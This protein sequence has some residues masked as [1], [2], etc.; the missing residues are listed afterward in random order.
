M[1]ASVEI[2]I[3]AILISMACAI[4]GTFLVL[5]KMSMMTDSITHTILFGIVAAYFITHDLNSPFLIVGAALV[6]VLTVWL[7]ESIVKT[8]LV[9]EDSA[10]GLVFPLL[11]SFAIIMVTKFADSVHLDVDTVLLGELAFAPFDRLILF[12]NDVGA[13]GMWIGIILVA[14]NLLF[15]VIFFRVL[16]LSTFDTVLATTLGFSPIIVHYLLMTVVSITT[17]GAFQSVG[18]ILVIAFMIVPP[19][20]AYLLSDDVKMIILISALI[21]AVSSVFGYQLAKLLDASIAGAIAV[22]AG[23]IFAIV[24]VV[25]PKRGVLSVVL[26]RK[27][28]RSEF[29]ELSLLFHIANHYQTDREDIENNIVSLI[30]HVHWEEEALNKILKK[31]ASEGKI[32][33]KNNIICLT[34][35]GIEQVKEAYKKYFQNIDPDMKSLPISLKNTAFK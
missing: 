12:G 23:I 7:T 16:K 22:V 5:R 4:T 35:Y 28:Q 3:I 32:E 19:A 25:A 10:I 11:F 29:I 33:I 21:G 15:V 13:I 34:N 27:R 8:R 14:I 17:V 2:Q 1:S 26:K 9:S 20:T 24:L 30:D 6:G 31:L 18:S